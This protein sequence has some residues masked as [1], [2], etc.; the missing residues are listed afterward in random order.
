MEEYGIGRPSTYAPTI[1]TIEDRGYV[2]RDENKKLKPSDIAF[3]VNDLLVENF[4]N[5]VDYQ[6][7]AEMEETLDKIAEG[8]VEWRPMI[9]NFYGPF[10]E[11]IVGKSAE[12]KKSSTIGMREL[13]HDPKTNLPIFV[14]L[15]RFGPYAQLGEGGGDD[16]PRFAP[17]RPG[18][19]LDTITLEDAVKLFT[20]PRDLGLDET[21]G[22][23][24]VSTGR[25]GPYVKCGGKFYSLKNIDP[26]EITLEQAL[27]VIKEKNEAEANKIIKTFPGS[28]IQILHGRYGPYITDGKK[29]GRVPKDTEPSSLELTQCEEILANAKEKRPRRGKT[30][31]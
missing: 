10:H 8:A 30:K 7:T 13:G 2:E 28:D 31:K 5:I 12:L 15:G 20:L 14:R 25:F 19:T 4:K 11:S 18:Q 26:F 29:N 1:A 24:T 22:N 16:K 27:A 6:F 17:F 21:G 9:K 3:V 23:I